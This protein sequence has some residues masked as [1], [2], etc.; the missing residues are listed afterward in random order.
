MERRSC[1]NERKMKI[2]K[3]Q[4]KIYEK[5][6]EK[7]MRQQIRDSKKEFKHASFMGVSL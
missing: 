2:N 1:R 7:N 4:R 3:I 5:I 6:S